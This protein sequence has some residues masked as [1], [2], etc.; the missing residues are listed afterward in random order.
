MSQFV[1]WKKSENNYLLKPIMILT[2]S[3][4]LTKTGVTEHMD[5]RCNTLHKWISEATNVYHV[6]AFD[7]QLVLWNLRHDNDHAFLSLRPSKNVI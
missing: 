2:Y 7:F 4:D 3:Q 6:C 1:V 5:M